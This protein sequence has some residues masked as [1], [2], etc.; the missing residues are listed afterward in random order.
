MSPARSAP[1]RLSAPTCPN[2]PNHRR[3]AATRPLS[4]GKR[5]AI[6]RRRTVG[7]RSAWPQHRLPADDRRCGARAGAELSLRRP[8]RRRARRGNSAPRLTPP[9]LTYCTAACVEGDTRPLHH[10]HAIKLAHEV[11][12]GGPHRRRPGRAVQ[13]NLDPAVLLALWE[14][15]ERKVREVL[16]RGEAA[17]GPPAAEVDWQWPLGGRFGAPWCRA[18]AVP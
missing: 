9:P 11:H 1:V 13:G 8:C 17:D 10:A 16:R 5:C 6:L 12:A 3:S 18:G 14:A 2:S 7:G 4:Y 15:V